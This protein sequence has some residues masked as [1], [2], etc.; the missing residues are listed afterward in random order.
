[1]NKS[2]VFIL[3]TGGTIGSV[4][5]DPN[6]S[7]S[8]LAPGSFEN[9]KSYVPA[10][11]QY[12]DV[13]EFG[14]GPHFD[15]PLDSSEIKPKHWITMARQIKEAYSDY[16]GFI[17]L[18]GT[19][20]MAY[21][22]SG[23]SFIFENLSKPVIITGSQLP[24]SHPRTDGI[25]NFTNAI[26]LAA[27]KTF[28]LPPIPEVVICF[29]DKILRGNRATKVSSTQW[30]GFDSPNFPPLG[31]IGEQIKI[32][33]NLLLPMPY[34]DHE[35]M[36]YTDLEE[37]IV[38]LALFPGF[39]ARQFSSFTNDNC[40]IEGIVI[41]SF[42]AGNAPGD[43]DFL[44]TIETAVRNNI[45]ILN[46]SQC[47]EGSVE[48]GLYEASLG[49]LE[50][51][52]VSGLDMTT[53]AAMAK[54]MWAIGNHL[55][56]DIVAQLQINQRGEQSQNLF[57]LQYK[58]IP[59]GE[60]GSTYTD[61]DN[62]DLRFDK[63]N[64][65][66]ALIRFSDLSFKGVHSDTVVKLNIFV[67]IKQVKPDTSE[68]DDNCVASINCHWKGKPLNLI[69]DI[70][71]KVEQVFGD[72]NIRLSVVSPAGNVKFYHNGLY[73]ALFSNTKDIR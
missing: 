70:T 27:W 54:M 19:D 51:G 40:D 13:I 31:K 58:S 72:G 57:G 28:E 12:K 5:L 37:N 68:S 9:L 55:E 8:P 7:A 44:D 33:E 3:Y 25:S 21:T 42:G 50:R 65:N 18:H 61:K 67:N 14:A 4:P 46:V 34:Y 53:E 38:Q 47:L 10:L 39:G 35:C 36:I 64:L 71:E 11:E 22:S 66:K 26:Y 24:I 17:I 59:E 29:A 43:K 45:T 73:I 20:T 62:F 16:D 60:A 52:V 1:M 2:K 63:R 30:A 49:L 41:N 15:P 48:M 32:E 69:E 56:E 23:L 6:N